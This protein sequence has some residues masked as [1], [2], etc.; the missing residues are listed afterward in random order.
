M[1]TCRMDQNTSVVDPNGRVWGVQKLWVY[2]ASVFP[3]ASGIN[4][5]V[6]V[7]VTAD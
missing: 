3:S 4:P 1:G 6:T 2:D 7:M 5:M